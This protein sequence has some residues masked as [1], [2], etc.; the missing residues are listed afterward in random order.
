MPMR[1]RRDMRR[2]RPAGRVPQRPPLR[3]VPDHGPGAACES[4]PGRRDADLRCLGLGSGSMGLG[5]PPKGATRLQT[6]TMRGEG[7][8]LDVAEGR[9]RATIVN[10]YGR[11]G[12]LS[13]PVFSTLPGARGKPVEDPHR[14]RRRNHGVMPAGFRLERDCGRSSDFLARNESVMNAV[15]DLD[16]AARNSSAADI[17]C[18]VPPFC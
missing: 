3:Y 6:T 16:D 18:A 4:A 9:Q 8:K 14:A 1:I 7:L 11:G 12:L 13:R 5:T 15:V 2:S 17:S 10:V